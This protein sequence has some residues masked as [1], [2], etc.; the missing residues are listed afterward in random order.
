MTTS[1]IEDT[2]TQAKK[3]V[4]YGRSLPFVRI[5]KEKLKS[6]I[7]DVETEERRGAFDFHLMKWKEKTMFLSS[8]ESII[9]DDDFKAIVAMGESAVPYIISEIENTPSTLVWALNCIFNKKITNNPD[10]TIKEACK[11]WKKAL[12]K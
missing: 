9:E 8:S 5:K 3:F 6:G 1:V 12:K 2:A 4:T 11:L 7:Q 10:T